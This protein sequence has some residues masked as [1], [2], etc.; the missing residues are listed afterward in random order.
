MSSQVSLGTVVTLPGVFAP[1][2]RQAPSKPAYHAA[3]HAAS[4]CTPRRCSPTQG[5]L[6][7]APFPSSFPSH[8]GRFHS[9]R[10]CFFVAAGLRF[11]RPPSEH[12]CAKGCANIARQST[13][14]GAAHSLGPPTFRRGD[15]NFLTAAAE[16]TLVRPS[17]HQSPAASSGSSRRCCSSCSSCTGQSILLQM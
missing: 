2:Q 17:S 4:C 14:V 6:A 1:H 5:P 11:D 10:H 3:Y 13:R 9:C 7:T 15:S 16:A 12:A 8:A